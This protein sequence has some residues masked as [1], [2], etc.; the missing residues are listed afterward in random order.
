MNSRLFIQ[1]DQR[2]LRALS[3][4]VSQEM[5]CL[6]SKFNFWTGNGRHGAFFLVVRILCVRVCLELPLPILL[7]RGRC[8]C[9]T[10]L[11]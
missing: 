7:G 8:C 11:S 10:S 3:S 1:K 4:G 6:L 9:C 2:Y 5:V